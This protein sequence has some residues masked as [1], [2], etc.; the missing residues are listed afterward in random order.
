VPP[1]APSE[2]AAAIAGYV[3]DPE[4]RRRHGQASRQR[5]TEH[6]SLERMAESYANLYTGLAAD[7]LARS[8]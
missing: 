1:L 8:A 7:R 6:F 5:A 4:L 3:A 2:L